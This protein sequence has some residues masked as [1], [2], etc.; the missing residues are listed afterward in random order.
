MPETLCE[1]LKRA[2]K[3]RQ[4]DKDRRYF[5][6]VSALEKKR[7]EELAKGRKLLLYSTVP[8]VYF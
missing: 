6:M 7:K 1:Q 2:A 3:Q 5:S 4:E 8:K